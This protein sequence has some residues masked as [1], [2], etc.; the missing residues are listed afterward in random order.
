MKPRTR[1]INTLILGAG[2]FAGYTLGEKLV[3]K[4]LETPKYEITQQD[5]N[6]YLTSKKL[7]KI[8]Q[9]RKINNNIIGGDLE[10]L[11]KGAKELK[12]HEIKRKYHLKGELYE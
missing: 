6:Y 8:I 12:E 4:K 11:I 5:D 3:N 7:D 2:I 9:L 10:H 1:L